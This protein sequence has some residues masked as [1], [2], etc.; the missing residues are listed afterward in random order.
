M[1]IIEGM[2]DEQYNEICAAGAELVKRLIVLLQELG[3]GLDSAP[4]IL[5]VASA[6]INKGFSLD[7]ADYAHLV[8]NAK[9]MWRLAPKAGGSGGYELVFDP[10]HLRPDY[11]PVVQPVAVSAN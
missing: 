3:L 4:G 8:E 2:S 11:Q 7:S 10:P 1:Q 9:I 6:G 5:A